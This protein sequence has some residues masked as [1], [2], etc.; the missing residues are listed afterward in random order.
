MYFSPVSC[1]SPQSVA[2][3]V[4]G[5][6]VHAA[7]TERFAQGCDMTVKHPFVPFEVVSP[8]LQNQGVARD[9]VPVAAHQN[10][11]NLVFLR[12]QRE[13]LPINPRA[14]FGGRKGDVAV[15]HLA[16]CHPLP[17]ARRRTACAFATSTGNEKGFVM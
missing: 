8:H 3:S 9:G 15:F 5:L 10:F 4:N 2:L 17:D 7:G 14:A 6:D 12:A 11:K 16:G 1:C 13:R